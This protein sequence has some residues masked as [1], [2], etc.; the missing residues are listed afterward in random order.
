MEHSAKDGTPKIVEQ[1][2]LPLT[3]KGV[4]HRIIT[5]LGVMDVTPEGIQLVELAKDVT[6]D[7]IQGVTGVKLIA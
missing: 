7:E 3:G 4:V 5:D 2:A 1:C 6:L